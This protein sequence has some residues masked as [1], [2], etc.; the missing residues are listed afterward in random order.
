MNKTK[1]IDEKIPRETSI[2]KATIKH[3]DGHM[4]EQKGISIH[5]TYHIMYISFHLQLCKKEVEELNMEEGESFS[6]DPIFFTG[7]IRSNLLS[8]SPSLAA[9]V[10]EDEARRRQASEAQIEVSLFDSSKYLT[11]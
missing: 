8:R 7:T 10:D 9:S 3:K 4:S 1:S 11:F 5:V 2:V 6:E